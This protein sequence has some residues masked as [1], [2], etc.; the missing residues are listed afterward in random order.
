[1]PVISRQTGHTPPTFVYCWASVADVGPTINQHRLTIPCL[2]K[3]A[4]DA[5]TY[6][7]L[8]TSSQKAIH[9][10]FARGL[11][12]IGYTG[13]AVVAPVAET[14]FSHRLSVYKF[15]GHFFGLS[16]RKISGNNRVKNSF[17][18][19]SVTFQLHA[20][21]LSSE[22]AQSLKSYGHFSDPGVGIALSHRHVGFFG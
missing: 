11:S 20:H 5:N 10:C 4:A 15:V 13:W 9:L 21:M 12:F 7:L 22:I 3:S 19:E 14:G 17:F 2:L 18:L 1:M 6:T 8:T 16:Y